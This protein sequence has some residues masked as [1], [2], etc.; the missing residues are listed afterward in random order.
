MAAGVGRAA[1]SDRSRGRGI[2]AFI[3]DLD[4]HFGPAVKDQMLRPDEAP[5]DP[6][7][8]HLAA[9]VQALVAD[10]ARPMQLT[11]DEL[12]ERLGWTG[13]LRYRNRHAFP[14]PAIYTANEAARQKL[15]ARL[16]QLSGGYVVLV[17]P[18][19]AGKSS[20]WRA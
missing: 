13:R 4:L 12:F 17:G 7:L 6:D 18:A 14:V 16:N 5:Q 15:H 3:R 1:R 9:T 19:G 20:C 11:R 8:E 10:P 2:A